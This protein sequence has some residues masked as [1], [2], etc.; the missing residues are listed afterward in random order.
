MSLW[1]VGSSI[2]PLVSASWGLSASQVGWLTTVVQLGFVLGTATSAVLNVADV[3]PSRRLF[4]LSAVCAAAVNLPLAFT[5]SYAVALLS[6][7]MTGFCLAG[8]YPPAMKMA[9]TWFR[10]RR[11]VAVGTVV[12]ALTVGKALP[13]LAGAFAGVTVQAIAF[14]SS[15]AALVA[16]LLVFT[17][18]R[19]G[20]YEFPSRTFS[21]S[22]VGDVV[23]ERN[24]RLA[25][26]GYLGHMAELYR[27]Y[28]SSTPSFI[29]QRAVIS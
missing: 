21:W 11:G 9:S 13:Y 25:T 14:L 8:V 17:R 18:Y 10:A 6:R 16:A 5:T 3:V 19:D 24:W 20:P 2:G 1:L 22:R 4:A 27:T 7:F 15:G 26:G 28:M 12:G 23:R 29:L